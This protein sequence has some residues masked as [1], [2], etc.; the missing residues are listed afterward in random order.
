MNPSPTYLPRLAYQV[1]DVQAQDPSR[2][3]ICILPSA[4]LAR[5]LWEDIGFL[6]KI[7]PDKY[8]SPIE[9][10]PEYHAQLGITTEST[11]EVAPGRNKCLYLHVFSKP[12]PLLLTTLSALSTRSP[13]QEYFARYFHEISIHDTLTLKS[14]AQLCKQLGYESVDLVD[15]VGTYAIRGFV[16]DVFSPVYTDPLRFEFCGDQIEK[17]STFNLNT[18]HSERALGTAVV[19][20]P[21][22]FHAYEHPYLKEIEENL[23]T[24]P[25]PVN[26]KY[27][28]IDALR[29]AGEW[30]ESDLVEM[31]CSP[32]FVFPELS[33]AGA[34]FII[35]NIPSCLEKFS[36][37]INPDSESPLLPISRS[38]CVSAFKLNPQDIIS[39]TH[40]TDLDHDPTVSQPA[41]SSFPYDKDNRHAFFHEWLPVWLKNK[42]QVFFSYQSHL[43][44]QQI[45]KHLEKSNLDPR[46]VT[47]EA[48]PIS[49]SFIDEKR[50]YAAIRAQDLFTGASTLDVPDQ[51]KLKQFFSTLSALEEGDFVIHSHHG[52][53]KYLG[54]QRIETNDTF[55]EYIT[56]EFLHQDKLY[57]PIYRLH[58]IQ[59]YRSKSLESVTLDSLR[60]QKFAKKKRKIQEKITRFAHELIELQA[61]RELTRTDAFAPL[62]EEETFAASFPFDETKDQIRSIEEVLRDLEKTLPMDRLLCGDVGFGKTEVAFRAIFRAL[63]HKRQA[64]LLTPTT[65]LAHQHHHTIKERFRDHPYTFEVLSRF[66]SAKEQKETIQKLKS[67]EVGCIVGTHRL[68]QKDVNLKKLGLV[69]ID[70]EQKFGVKQKE[71]FK[72][73]RVQTHTL[74]LSATPIPRTLNQAFLGLRSL[75]I[76][77]TPPTNR[78]PIH[79]T[80]TKP[81]SSALKPA[82]E[83]ELA[84]GGQIFCV[85]PRVADI[86]N[87]EHWVNTYFSTVA[88]GIAHGQMPEEHLEDIMID[89]YEKKFPILISTSIIE[90]G[91]DVP[92]ANT[93]LIFQA[94]MFGLSQ[95]YQ[96]RGRIGRSGRQAYCYLLLPLR[97]EIPKKAKKRLEILLRYHDLG[98]GFQV[99]QHD[100]EVR[101]AGNVLG[102]EQTGF[103]SEI[104]AELYFDMLKTA[105]RKLQGKEEE[106]I[107]P[108]ITWGWESLIPGQYLPSIPLRL[109]VYQSLSQADSMEAVDHLKFEIENR[110]GPLPMEGIH[111]IHLHKIRLLCTQLGIR[112]LQVRNNRLEMT[113]VEHPQIDMQAVLD[114]FSKERQMFQFR[115][116]EQLSLSLSFQEPKQVLDYLQH[117]TE[118]AKT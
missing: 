85:V 20:S 81:D 18:Q 83:H 74:S 46:S 6:K 71:A 28:M 44:L 95:L 113:F 38:P 57:I 59:K 91:L 102:E 9:I 94:N 24:I 1:L 70:E 21:R 30:E 53:A 77:T 40:P 45:L 19:L 52:V 76:I 111:L 101:G 22:L 99:A 73:I 79:T 97:E 65:L 47:L 82:I 69:V 8:P 49:A 42:G 23:K 54:L 67:G 61:K 4:T 106:S 80:L 108:E 68:L 92:N 90:S 2:T 48:R 63:S 15:E 3:L 103:I 5:K 58:L 100:L 39:A 27:E 84:R 117:F 66:R 10:Y 43:H 29:E 96:L 55:G 72:R 93:M 116:S 25:I 89:F 56:L 51:R 14:L 78:L 34:K 37:S 36:A 87:V 114:T 50:K 11:H 60:D 64:A 104:G 41:L 33:F 13:S 16:L 12:A 17:L 107:D 109:E 35:H 86:P 112:N 31:C 7:A 88:Y 105:V 32:G 115:S 62:E 98:S 118:I 26:K 75:S 110:F